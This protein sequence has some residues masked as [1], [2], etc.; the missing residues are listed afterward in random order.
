VD[1]ERRTPANTA[2]VLIDHVVGFANTLGSQSVHDNVNGAVALAAAAKG[3]G[4][5]LVVTLGPE[6]DPRGGLYPALADALGDHPLIHR[7]GCF[8]AFDEPE[9][10]AAVA[11][12]GA[13]HLVVAGLTTEGCVLQTALGALRRDLEVSLVLDATASLTQVSHDAAVARLAQLGVVP[14]SWLSF[15]AEIQRTYANADTLPVFR[16]LQEAH[17]PGISMLMATIQA[18][19]S[20]A[21]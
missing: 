14:T 20:P 7:G 19:R 2:V 13:R 18:A 9:F 3:F 4:I 12:T 15:A 10:E 17:V 1:I 11:A 8:D 21:T 6:G 16:G 5:P